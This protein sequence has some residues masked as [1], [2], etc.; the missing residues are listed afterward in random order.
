MHHLGDE[1]IAVLSLDQYG[2]ATDYVV[3]LDSGTDEEYFQF[4][5]L[6]D[7]SSLKQEYRAVPVLE[8]EVV[9]G[10][11][12]IALLGMDLVAA[13]RLERERTWTESR[14]SQQ[15]LTELLTQ[16]AVIALGSVIAVG[17][18]INNATVLHVIPSIQELLL[19]DIATAQN[20][21]SRPGSVSAVWIQ[22]RLKPASSVL[23][24]LYPGINTA[25]ELRQRS[26]LLGEYVLQPYANFQPTQNFVDAIAFQL[27]TLGLLAVFVAIFIIFQ[28]VKTTLIRRQT[29]ISRLFTL[30]VSRAH[31]K[32]IYVSVI[33]LIGILSGIVGI[34]LGS[35][36]LEMSGFGLDGWSLLRD[37]PHVMIKAIVISALV[38]IGSALIADSVKMDTH[39]RLWRWIVAIAA[40]GLVGYGLLLSSGLFG[41]YAAILGLC[42]FVASVVVPVTISG[43]HQLCTTFTSKSI[44][45]TM[46]VRSA[47]SS[48]QVLRTP[49]IAFSLAIGTAMG[50]DLQVANF[51]VD[52]ESMLSQRLPEGI[53]IDRAANL[54]VREIDA[55][56]SSIQVREYWRG[57]GT[58]NEGS[59]RITIARMDDWEFRR[60]DAPASSCNGVFLNEIGAR[61]FGFEVGDS[62][63]ISDS[64]QTP[65]STVVCHVFRSYGEPTAQV[66]VAA[67]QW[68][69]DGL[70]RDRIYI[71]GD[72]DTLQQIASSLQRLRPELDIQ[73]AGDIRAIAKYIFDQ[74]FVISGLMS[75]VALLIAVIGFICALV[76]L[77]S[78]RDLEFRLLYMMG[79]P[80]Q[81]VFL[82]TALTCLWIGL[83]TVLCSMLLAMGIA[84]LLCEYGNPRAF[85][86]SIDMQVQIEP[87][88]V[89]G[90]V[91]L[92]GAVIASIEP[93]RRTLK[94]VI[95]QPVPDAT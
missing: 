85:G 66:I 78:S 76:V 88:V 31:Y 45:R 61:R 63:E 84:W 17:E 13:S 24:W 60:Y 68:Q 5:K 9:H 72:E 53:R 43:L 70:I 74:T 6:W 26:I 71:H 79:Y 30:G 36:F 22:P 86:W 4:R 62:I 59:L 7:Q 67:D 91:G 94:R 38:A 1:I 56:G 54:D 19:A 75:V 8:G 14:S 93:M 23:D 46:N 33:G 95:N 82:N 37:K 52:F 10:G 32:S 69:P 83:I 81:R 89:P 57:S 90:I 92:L 65:Y 27:G 64:T 18:S 42:L 28:S 12:R 49:I 40:I 48:I 80:T 15:W 39:T 47:I 11:R 51:R 87:F 58:L 21:L 34:G 20:V 2:R 73:E 77:L 44:L 3:L 55:F 16:D 41:V 25:F 29:E 35:W 50:I